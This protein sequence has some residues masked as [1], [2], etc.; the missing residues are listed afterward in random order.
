M[1]ECNITGKHA[2]FQYCLVFVEVVFIDWIIG[3]GI[4]GVA[5]IDKFPAYLQF[6]TGKYIPFIVC[7]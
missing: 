1:V 3:F 5:G 7:F 6:R 4:A 2:I